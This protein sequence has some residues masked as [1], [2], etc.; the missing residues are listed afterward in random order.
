MS[1][2]EDI[3]FSH[4]SRKEFTYVGT[5]NS[6]ISQWTHLEAGDDGG[7]LRLSLPPGAPFISELHGWNRKRLHVDNNG[8]QHRGQPW[9]DPL[10]G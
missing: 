3:I 7:A 4:K 9:G 2:L 5:K 1:D 10:R 8:G 6:G